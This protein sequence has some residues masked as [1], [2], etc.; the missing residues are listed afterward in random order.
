MITGPIERRFAALAV[1]ESAWVHELA[2]RVLDAAQ[3]VEVLRPPSAATMLIELTESVQHLPFYL[4]EVVVSEASVLLDGHRGDAL[5]I[6]R[7]LERALAVAVCDAAAE[8]GVLAD[9]VTALVERA[10]AA[11]ATTRREQAEAVAATR[12]SFEVIG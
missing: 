12:V 7:D 11:V 5:V 4:G 6:G 1:A 8:A 9:E 10:E 2:E 3:T